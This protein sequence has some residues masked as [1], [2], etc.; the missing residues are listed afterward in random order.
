MDGNISVSTDNTTNN[1]KDDLTEYE[2][3]DEA[4]SAPIAANL[5]S[6]PGQHKLPAGQQQVLDVGPSLD[7]PTNVPLFLLLNARS[8]FN[9]ADNLA[10][11]L[12]QIGP[13]FCLV[14]ETFERANKSLSSVLPKQHFES[15]SQFRNNKAPGGGCAIIF[16]QT[17]FQVSSLDVSIPEGIE[18]CWALCTP[19]FTSKHAQKV[20]R[21]AI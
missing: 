16:N 8:I 10:D 11:L 1:S 7:Q 15:I 13:D 17:R 18:C 12:N 5:I 4:F 21:I 6:V 19:K 3:E 9:K 20:K 2:T 14:S